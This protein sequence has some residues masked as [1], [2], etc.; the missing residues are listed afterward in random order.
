MW[1]GGLGPV[2]R[3][4]QARGTVGADVERPPVRVRVLA[5]TDH[6]DLPPAGEDDPVYGMALITGRVVVW[7]LVHGCLSSH[8][9]S[10]SPAQSLRQF[11]TQTALVPLTFA[12]PDPWTAT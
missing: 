3:L 2:N 12:V 4:N 7:G 9:L 11:L 6:L 1:L 10:A 5:E 8:F